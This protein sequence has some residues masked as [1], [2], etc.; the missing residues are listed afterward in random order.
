[1]LTSQKK[2]LADNTQQQNFYTLK[3]SLMKCGDKIKTE[4]IKV[5]ILTARTDSFTDPVFTTATLSITGI[6]SC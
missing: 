5:K 3:N 4:S 6:K 2:I 1:M